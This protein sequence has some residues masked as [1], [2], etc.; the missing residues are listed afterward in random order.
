M[1]E[2][3]TLVVKVVKSKVCE[4]VDDKFGVGND[5]NVFDTTDKI[6]L[7]PYG[8]TLEPELTKDLVDFR[9]K[10]VINKKFISFRVYWEQ[11]QI[12][13]HLSGMQKDI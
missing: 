9:F 1:R 7:H 4:K 13:C 5:N 10:D 11:L 3:K 12:Q 2:Y 6:N 8:D